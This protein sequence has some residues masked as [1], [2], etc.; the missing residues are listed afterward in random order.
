[1]SGIRLGKKIENQKNSARTINLLRIEMV[2][3]NKLDIY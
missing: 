2:N 3:E 1:M